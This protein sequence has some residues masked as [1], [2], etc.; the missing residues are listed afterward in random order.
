MRRTVLALAYLLGSGLLLSFLLA[1]GERSWFHCFAHLGAEA[2]AL[3]SLL[4][5][6]ELMPVLLETL[7]PPFGHWLLFL[8]HY[9]AGLGFALAVILAS[10]PKQHATLFWVFLLFLAA[11]LLVLLPITSQHDCDRKGTDAIFS[12]MLLAPLGYVLALGSVYLSRPKRSA[13]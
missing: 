3:P 6:G 8:L 10:H 1:L 4:A 7:T 11:V 2:P 13:T 12:L 9:G 5:P